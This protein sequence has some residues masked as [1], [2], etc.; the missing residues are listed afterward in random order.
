M[1]GNDMILTI[2]RRYFGETAEDRV[3]RLIKTELEYESGRNADFH[4]GQG[5]E[6]IVSGNIL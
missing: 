3:R 4:L 2:A 5:Y 1:C 6:G